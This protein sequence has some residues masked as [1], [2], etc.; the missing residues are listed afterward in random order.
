[1]PFLACGMYKVKQGPHLAPGLD[2]SKFPPY[3]KYHDIS[4]LGRLLVAIKSR[5][6]VCQ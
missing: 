3:S 2:D 5:R 4:E 6:P 1:M